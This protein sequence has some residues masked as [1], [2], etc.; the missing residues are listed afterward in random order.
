MSF[1]SYCLKCKKDTNMVDMTSVKTKNN[2]NMIRGKCIECGR[3][4]CKFL[5]STSGGDIVSTMSK[6]TN[7]VTFPGQRFPGEIHLPGHNFTGPGTRLDSRLNDDNSPKQWSMPV[8]R[9][10][11]AAYHHDSAYAEHSDT[12]NRNIAD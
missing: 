11:K 2:R 10:D 3:T 6:L 1:S 12:A 9:V 8:D 7:N 5:K 4:K